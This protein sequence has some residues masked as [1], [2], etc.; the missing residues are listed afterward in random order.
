MRLNVCK[1][2]GLDDM[3]SRVLKDLADV[4]VKS[5]AIIFENSW[6]SD[7]VPGHWE[8]ESMTSIFK[9][10]REEDLGNYR[11]VS[12]TSVPRKFMEQIL[13]EAE[14]QHVQDKKVIR[15]SQHGFTRG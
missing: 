13:L 14:L 9:K 12:L 6:L 4:A 10:V 8:K 5:L 11:L 2:M 7:K 1:S 15:D 3:Y